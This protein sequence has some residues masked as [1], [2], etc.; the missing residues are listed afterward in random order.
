[1][2]KAHIQFRLNP[3]S[4]YTGEIEK[5]ALKIYEHHL[6]QGVLPRQLFTEALLNLGD[7]PLPER[8]S[9]T[10]VA[11]TLKRVERKLD[12]QHAAMQQLIIEA[13]RNLDLAGYVNHQG[14]TIA[15]DLGDKIPESVYRTMFDSSHAQEFDT[16]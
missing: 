8:S 4:P 10:Q 5:K 6:A 9:L 7:A 15:D 2:D 3:D 12:E 11:K 13:L 14:R 16:D 1:M